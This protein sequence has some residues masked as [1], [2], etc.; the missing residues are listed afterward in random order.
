M[1]DSW[2]LFQRIEVLLQVIILSPVIL[3][4]LVFTNFYLKQLINNES[5]MPQHNRQHFYC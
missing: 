1:T 4:M 2:Q 5:K 3:S